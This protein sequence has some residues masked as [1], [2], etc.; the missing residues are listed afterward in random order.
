MQNEI[1]EK[2]EA[3]G[4]IINREN[5]WEDIK[6]FIFDNYQLGAYVEV[7]DNY[8][9]QV[10]AGDVQEK[11]KLTRQECDEKGLEGYKR[12]QFR[13][14]GDGID[15]WIPVNNLSFKFAINVILDNFHNFPLSQNTT[16]GWEIEGGTDESMGVVDDRCYDYGYNRHYDCTAY[17]RGVY[18]DELELVVDG[19]HH[20]QDLEGGIED[21]NNLLNSL[22]WQTDNGCGFHI[23]IGNLS[24]KTVLKTFYLFTEL[25]DVIYSFLHPSRA[26][27]DYCRKPKRSM[28]TLN[29][30]ILTTNNQIL[31]LLQP[32]TIRDLF[33]NNRLSRLG[34]NIGSYLSSRGTLEIRCFDSNI[35]HLGDYIKFTDALIAFCQRVSFR[36]IEKLIDNASRK[37]V[38]NGF[39]ELAEAIMLDKE[40]KGY[41]YQKIFDERN[42]RGKTKKA[43]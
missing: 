40:T 38:E 26:E 2:L 24:P 28:R 35:N 42:N 9:H 8:N 29:E 37:Y 32:E 10:Y 34:F 21:L 23:H 30:A 33:Q 36:R 15:E 11:R 7:S 22:H 4:V 41:L 31:D 27:G 16:W 12:R 1:I 13:I 19:Y 20:T 43:V 17:V 6:K 18:N 25:E 14:Y 5:Y 3:V 39:L